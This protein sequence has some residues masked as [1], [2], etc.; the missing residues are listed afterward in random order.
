M[1]L[2]TMPAL[3]ADECVLKLLRRN[4]DYCAIEQIWLC[5]LEK[6][7]VAEL[8]DPKQQA[9]QQS[10]LFHVLRE[11]IRVEV[12]LNNLPKAEAYAKCALQ[13]TCQPGFRVDDIFEM[14]HE[15]AHLQEV[16]S[17]PGDAEKIFA[18]ELAG[19]AKVYGELSPISLHSWQDLSRNLESQRKFSEAYGAQ[20]RQLIILMRIDGPDNIGL[21]G[22]YMDMGRVSYKLDK[23]DQSVVFYRKALKLLCRDPAGNKLMIQQAKREFCRSATKLA[24]VNS[25]MN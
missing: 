1:L 9:I 2:S 13:L 16:Q 19:R 8:Q 15:V 25:S 3:S 4:A 5:E 12:V 10:K 20:E 18:A 23:L 22:I 6:L 14:E 17:R 7:Q 11:L 24:S 21:A